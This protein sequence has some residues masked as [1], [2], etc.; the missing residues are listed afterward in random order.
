M[1]IET[2]RNCENLSQDSQFS[3][4]DSNEVPPTQKQ[5][6]YF[7]LPAWNNEL[8]LVPV[9]ISQSEMDCLNPCMTGT[10][11]VLYG[12]HFFKYSLRWQFLKWL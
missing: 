11:F 8:S 10:V 3:D 12:R 1:L 6:H 9:S 4:Q 2:D 5:K 7:S